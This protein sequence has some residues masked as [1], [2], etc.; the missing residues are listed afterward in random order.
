MR[1][2][3]PLERAPMNTPDAIPDV[4]LE[5]RSLFRRHEV[6]IAL[7]FLFLAFVLVYFWSNIV[8]A[9]HPGE[10]GVLWSRIFG[11]QTNLIYPEGTHLILPI[12]K[13][14]IYNVRY[15]KVD[16]TF[17]VL[18]LD[19]LEIAVDTTIR[20]KPVDKLIG[21]LHQQIGPEYVETIVVPEVGQ[22]VR[23]TIGRYRPE[24]LYTS[25]F[26]EIQQNILNLSRVQVRERFVLLDD[27]EILTITMPRL[28]AESIQRKLQEEQ[29]SLAMQ[30]RIS[31]ERQEAERK[32]IEA[33]GIRAFQ[34]IVSPGLNDMLLQ[35]KGIEATLELAKSPNS[36]VVIIGGKGGLPM[37]L[38]ADTFAPVAPRTP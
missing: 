15:Q 3:R 24:E 17:R 13:M 12:N 11:T 6:K 7:A 4:V 36:K 8:I 28:V 23:S 22:A 35:F 2:R 27:V 26:A 1:L 33:D 34:D 30:F 10:A 9:I 18:S 25:S 37:I 19:G 21:R 20:F 14:T 29:T 38:G 16:R 5:S 31:R 32:R